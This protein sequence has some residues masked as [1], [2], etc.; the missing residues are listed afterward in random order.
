MTMSCSRSR[1]EALRWDRPAAL[2]R[3]RDL[4]EGRVRL[5]AFPDVE[6]HDWEF[7]GRR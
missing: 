6:I 3:D 7:G 1:R 4:E 5:D 2:S